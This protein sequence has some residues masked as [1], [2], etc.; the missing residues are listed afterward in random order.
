MCMVLHLLYF[1][2]DKRD[3]GGRERMVV[4]FVSDLRQAD[5]FLR[6]LPMKLTTSI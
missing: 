5:G 4:E 3:R 6:F 1:L 2:K